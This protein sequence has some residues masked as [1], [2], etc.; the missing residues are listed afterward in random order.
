MKN[1]LAFF[2]ALLLCSASF[3]QEAQTR[4]ETERELNSW[5]FD[6]YFNHWVGVGSGRIQEGPEFILNYW[7]TPLFFSTPAGSYWQLTDEEIV[8]GLASSHETLRSLGYTYTHVPDR[9]ITVH[10]QNGGAID[11]IWSRRAADNT[12]VQRLVVRFEVA[13]MNG[14]WKVVGIYADQTTVEKDNNTLEG[15]WGY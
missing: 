3:G 2:T 12:E 6:T 1:S 8:A 7:G 4:E 9:E 15:A 14:T 11:A 5:F 10:H 13:R